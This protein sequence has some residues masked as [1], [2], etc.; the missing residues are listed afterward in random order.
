[1]K[2]NIKR[3][4]YLSHKQENILIV[5]LILTR[6]TKYQRIDICILHDVIEKI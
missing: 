6:M 2:E 1:M 3:D 4:R 5:Y